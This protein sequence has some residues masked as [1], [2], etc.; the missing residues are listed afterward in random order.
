MYVCMNVCNIHLGYGWRIES[1]IHHEEREWIATNSM[2][3]QSII[4][5]TSKTPHRF[6]FFVGGSGG[7]GGGGAID[8]AGRILHVGL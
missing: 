8:L 6:F 7:G 1:M 3:N 5:E 4:E 2:I